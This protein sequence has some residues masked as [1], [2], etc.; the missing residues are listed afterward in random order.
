MPGDASP[1]PPRL[2]EPR[3]RAI[4]DAA[5][6]HAPTTEGPPAMLDRRTFSDPKG[7]LNPNKPGPFGR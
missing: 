3:W 1:A 6:D 4:L 7:F 2:T 5:G